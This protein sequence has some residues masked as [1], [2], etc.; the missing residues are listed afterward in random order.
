[1]KYP[2]IVLWHSPQG[3]ANQGTYYFGNYDTVY[4]KYIKNFDVANKN[5]C[6]VSRHKTLTNAEI[7]ARKQIASRWANNTNLFIQLSRID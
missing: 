6:I 4:A 1:M 3:H 7:A 2:Y 5:W